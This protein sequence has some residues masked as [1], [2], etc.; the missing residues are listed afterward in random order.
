FYKINALNYTI[1]VH[2]AIKE[3]TTNSSK[4]RFEETNIPTHLISTCMFEGGIKPSDSLF[5]ELDIVSTKPWWR[6]SDYYYVHTYLF[7]LVKES[8]YKNL[9]A[10]KDFMKY[11]DYP[12]DVSY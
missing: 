9:F 2:D 7:T 4:N 8:R 5:E 12:K 3:L 1:K 10:K 11:E 6:F